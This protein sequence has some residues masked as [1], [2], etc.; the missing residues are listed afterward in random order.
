MLRLAVN[1]QA[2]PPQA[3]RMAPWE[4]DCMTRIS[5][6]AALLGSLLLAGAVGPTAAFAAD[7]PAAAAKPVFKLSKSVQ[8]LLSAAQKLQQAGDNAGAVAKLKEAEALPGRNNDDNYMINVLKLNAG[9]A[10][11]DNTLLEESIEGALASGRVEPSEQP[12]FIRNLGALALQRNDT[13]KAITQFNKLVD[14]NPGD[15]ETLVNIAELQR[16][17]GQNA[18]AVAT[19]VKAAQA[20]KA[21]GITPPEPWL[22]RAL[23][24]AYDAKLPAEIVTTSENLVTYYPN[25]TNWHDALVIFRESNKLDEQ[26]GLDLLRTLR[27]TGG[28]AGERDYYE[29]ADTAT[30]RGLP[31]EAKAVLDEGIAKGMLSAAKPGIKELLASVNPKVAGDRAS[32]AGLEKEAAAAKTGKSAQSTGDAYLGYA[33]YARAAA[34]Y[35]LAMT[36]GGV[37]AN[38]LNL[39]LGAALALSGDKA[40]ADTALKLVS[41]GPRAQLARYWLIWNARKA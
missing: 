28:L 5:S 3:R 7:K 10:L 9:I 14:L 30:T 13:A 37:D 2:T 12:K 19:F 27:A 15:T 39:R 26:T 36:K 33:N 11:K 38:L 21:A 25:P 16:R 32:L 35:R 22:R 34:M 40:G 41:T 17:A 29:Y 1:R 24:V 18:A 8:P 23:A 20:S 31:G 6:V 4:I